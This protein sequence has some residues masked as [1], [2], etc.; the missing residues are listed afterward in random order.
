MK[1]LGFLAS[2]AI[3]CGGALA[4][5]DDAGGSSANNGGTNNG[6]TNNGGTN[7]GGTNNGGTNNGGTN[8]GGTNN[9]ANNG[10]GP[11]DW[12]VLASYLSDVSIETDPDGGVDIDGDG[13]TDNAL[14]TLLGNL[15][16]LLGDLD[17]ND[18]LREN[19]AS[20][21]IRIGACWPTLESGMVSNATGVSLDIIQTLDTDDD[22][23]TN[24]EVLAD[25]SSLD[26]NGTPN[27][28]FRNATITDGALQAGPEDF[29]FGVPLGD[30]V[31]EIVV[32]DAQFTGQV[33]EDALGITLTDGT[34]AGSVPL[35]S[36]VD[37]L[38]AYVT[39][40]SCSCLGLDTPLI[41]GSGSSFNCTGIAET[42]TCADLGQDNC[43]TIYRLCATAVL[44]IG[45]ATDIDADGDG[46]NDSLSM[47]LHVQMAGTQ[48]TG[49]GN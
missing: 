40:E 29:P 25:P 8:N 30:I 49:V 14:G 11:Y 31:L 10:G 19:L 45:D 44:I 48:I 27:V 26:S 23:A 22:P 20:G 7:N 6:G 43:A 46:D 24:D 37:G 4:C 17:L 3:V 15:S 33:G 34:I 41:I 38:N 36:I 28:R 18:Q 9:G 1:K 12:N 16:G 5:G 32:S 13:D 21:G 2:I 47:L 39:G 42:S 35:Q